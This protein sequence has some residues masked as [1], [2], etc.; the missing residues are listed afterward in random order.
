VFVL[1]LGARPPA[2]EPALPESHSVSLAA[3]PCAEQQ[4]SWGMAGWSLEPRAVERLSWLARSVG[5][6]LG[7]PRSMLSLGRADCGRSPQGSWR[8]MQVQATFEEWTHAH[9]PQT[10]ARRLAVDLRARTSGFWAELPTPMPTLIPSVHRRLPVR[11][12]AESVPQFG[13]S[14]S[15][16][17]LRLR[18][19]SSDQNAAPRLAGRCP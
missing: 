19:L 8:S 1:W 11:G 16:R 4:R 10:E 13:L 12:A 3:T 9:I 6:R 15:A 5:L 17:Q 2:M 14:L 18:L 7:P